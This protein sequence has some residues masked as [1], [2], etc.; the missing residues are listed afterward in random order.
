MIYKKTNESFKP[1]L[2]KIALF[3]NVNLNIRNRINYKYSY[4][5]IKLE[6]QNS[7]KLLINYLKDHKLNSSKYLDFLNWKETF[8]LI[9]NKSQYTNEGRSIILNL[10]NNM[11][12]KR[13]NFD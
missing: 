3:F 6:N 4:F 1:I 7:I 2:E 11:N 8:Q 9:L 10:K 13:T 12:D 5:I